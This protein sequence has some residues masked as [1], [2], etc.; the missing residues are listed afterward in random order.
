M[1][2]GSWVIESSSQ[3]QVEMEGEKTAGLSVGSLELSSFVVSDVFL[4]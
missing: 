2:W 1:T 4:I 3:L